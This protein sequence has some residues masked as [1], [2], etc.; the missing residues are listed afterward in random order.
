MAAGVPAIATRVGAIPEVVADGV[1]GLLLEPRSP[2]A[3]AA[4][5]HTLMCD[6][7]ALARMGEASRATIAARYSIPR[8]AGEM[9]ALYANLE[10]RARRHDVAGA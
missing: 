1:N 10:A 6:R 2:Q 7:A 9:R 8:L 3:I 4:A 5:I